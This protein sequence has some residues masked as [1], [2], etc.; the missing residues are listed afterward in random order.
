MP[1][2]S[3]ARL[4]WNQRAALVPHARETVAVT[5]GQHGDAPFRLR[6]VSHPVADDFAG[7]Q[8]LNRRD[9]RLDRH[10]RFDAGNAPANLRRKNAIHQNARPHHV[11]VR[12]RQIEK[13]AAVAGV[14]QCHLDFFL[15]QHVQHFLEPRKLEIG[16]GFVRLIGLREVRH[17]AFKFQRFLGQNLFDQRQCLVPTN[18][19]A[20]HAGVDFH[21]HRHPFADVRRQ[22]LRVCGR[23][24]PR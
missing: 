18:A 8:R 13:P 23:H 22:F 12:V 20:A 16:K 7:L 5:D 15:L 14:A 2:M 19:V 9:A 24:V 6:G 10:D 3:G 1:P 11:E 4:P 21:M 17:R